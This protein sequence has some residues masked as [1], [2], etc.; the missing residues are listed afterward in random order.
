MKYLLIIFI[1]AVALAPLRH[2]IPSRRQRRIARMREYAAV[3]GLFVEFRQLP[4]AARG[5]KSRAELPRGDI[6]YYGKRLPP[7][8]G[9]GGR[10]GSWA[11]ENHDWRALHGSGPLPEALAQSPGDI[12]AASVDEN[13]CGIYW[14]E[15]GDEAAVE[16]IREAIEA[17][18]GT[19][20]R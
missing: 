7:Q 14:Q 16:Q 9:D 19:L 17:W 10:R 13:S 2:A 12:L 15:T 11:Q 6:I 20:G 8:R 4:G 18:A 3:H 5:D 1:I